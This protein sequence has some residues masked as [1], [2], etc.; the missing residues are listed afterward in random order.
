MNLLFFNLTGIDI[1]ILMI[2]SILFLYS[3]YKL[4][5]DKYLTANERLFW[6]IIFLIFNILGAIAYWVWG[7]NKKRTITS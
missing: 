1:M 5:V 7:N 2:P 4:I 3:F 6:I